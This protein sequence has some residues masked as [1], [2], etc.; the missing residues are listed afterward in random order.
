MDNRQCH[1]QAPLFSLKDFAF[2]YVPVYNIKKNKLQDEN[3]RT[4]INADDAL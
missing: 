3:T 1:A 4:L 2:I